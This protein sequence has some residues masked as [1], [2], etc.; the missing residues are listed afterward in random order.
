M[1]R[2]V[3]LTRLELWLYL[4]AAVA[5]GTMGGVA[6]T[7]WILD[8]RIKVAAMQALLAMGLRG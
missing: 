8:W 5:L 3:I 2:Q 7:L 4:A 6:G 1:N